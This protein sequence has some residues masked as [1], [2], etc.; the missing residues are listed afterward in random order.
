MAMTAYVVNTN[1]M[2]FCPVEDS[3]YV[4][5]AE[6][7]PDLARTIE[8]EFIDGNEEK[9]D[10]YTARRISVRALVAIAVAAAE[11]LTQQVDGNREGAYERVE[12][13]KLLEGAGYEVVDPEG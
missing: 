1:G 7:E 6:V 9:L 11:Y 5:L 8:A 10:E 12:L 2:G 4:E 3:D 13:S